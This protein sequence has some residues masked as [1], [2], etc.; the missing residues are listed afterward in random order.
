MSIQLSYERVSIFNG[1]EAW[2]NFLG[3]VQALK[4]VPKNYF[5][6]TQLSDLAPQGYPFA[7]G[8]KDGG[9]DEL[10]KSPG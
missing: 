8:F 3:T 10:D 1:L 2:P 7:G 6:C 9:S 4:T 5:G